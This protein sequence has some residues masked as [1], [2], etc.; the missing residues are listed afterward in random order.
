MENTPNSAQIQLRTS[1]DNR[2]WLKD[3]AQ[4]QD[5]S[6]NWLINKILADAKAADSEKK[7]AS[8]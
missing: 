4:K 2:A 6:V 1:P 8:H 3:K 5:R 7:N